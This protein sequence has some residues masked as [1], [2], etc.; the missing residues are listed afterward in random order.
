MIQLIIWPMYLS[1]AA[2]LQTCPDNSIDL[3]A[4][5]IRPA[6]SDIYTFRE[7]WTALVSD[8][9]YY[10]DKPQNGAKGQANDHDGFLYTFRK[11]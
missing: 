10:M 4:Q 3:R 11:I 5:K 7:I 9:A 8:L 6:I 1:H 2:R